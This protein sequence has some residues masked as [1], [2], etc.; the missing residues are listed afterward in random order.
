MRRRRGAVR[1]QDE[2]KCSC[3]RLEE[4]LVLRVLDERR[5]WCV[6]EVE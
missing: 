1:A 4:V 6:Q 2:R 3:V 5:R